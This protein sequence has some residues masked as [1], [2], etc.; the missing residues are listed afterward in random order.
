[1][2]LSSGFS[3]INYPRWGVLNT[4]RQKTLE[5]NQGMLDADDHPEFGH[6]RGALLKPKP[7]LSKVWVRKKQD[8]TIRRDRGV[9][10]KL[11]NRHHKIDQAKHV[12]VGRF[13]C[14]QCGEWP[15]RQARERCDL[16]RN[17]KHVVND[18]EQWRQWERHGCK[19]SMRVER[20]KVVQLLG[21]WA[22]MSVLLLFMNY[23]R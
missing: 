22:A 19:W 5:Q 18:R 4:F 12:R 3:L 11:L 1:M 2:L 23:S 21:E 15:L 20:G 9:R 13:F 17:L 6:R 14:I 10:H 7:C 16:K 8:G